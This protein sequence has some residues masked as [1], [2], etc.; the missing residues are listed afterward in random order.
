[1]RTIGVLLI[2]AAA[3]WTQPRPGVI[4][5]TD[6]G[7]DV[8]D[9]LA[10]AML[11]ALDARG[12]IRLLAVT[13]TKDN[14]QA[15]QFCEI[16]NRFYGRPE[17]PIGL[18]T[19]GVTPEDNPMIAVPVGRRNAAG[20]YVYPRRIQARR[21]VRDAV[22]VLREVL[23]QQPDASVRIVQVGFSTNLARLLAQ[24]GGHELAAR[25]VQLLSVMAGAFPGKPEYNVKMD[26]ASAA[27]VFAEWPTPVVVSGYEVGV[28][29]EYP[30][31]SIE[32]DFGY[33]EWHPVAD[34]Y[35]AYKTMPYDR[36]SWDL[37]SVLYA[38]RPDGGYFRLSSPGRVKVLDSGVTE[39]VKQAGGRHRHLILDPAQ[40]KR[41]LGTFVELASQKPRLQ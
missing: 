5:D 38:A 3:A 7:N 11:H 33:V 37:T 9:A 6:M 20:A 21:D 31:A 14:L 30:G 28:A 36:P 25:K 17:I 12:E 24:P 23:E 41:I 15:A 32:R 19:N 39:F 34:A 1:M 13:V 22:A 18:V 2:L 26:I 8:D 10:L 29:L 16:V 4:F 40:K 27:R 35:R